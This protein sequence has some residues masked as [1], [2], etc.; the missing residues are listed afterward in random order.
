MEQK[1]KQEEDQEAEQKNHEEI[2]KQEERDAEYE[3][4]AGLVGERDEVTRKG[5]IVRK[6]RKIES[7]KSGEVYGAI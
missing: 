7:L 4:N 6:K 2:S 1:K 3:Q 5:R